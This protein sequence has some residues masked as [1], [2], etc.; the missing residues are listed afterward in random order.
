V[1][2]AELGPLRPG[3]TRLPRCNDDR[4]HGFPWIGTTLDGDAH[5]ALHGGTGERVQLIFIVGFKGVSVCS[6]VAKDIN[7]L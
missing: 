7:V 2:L 1:L 4:L 6:R 3:I 5:A